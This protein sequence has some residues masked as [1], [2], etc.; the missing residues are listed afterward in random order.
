MKTKN[1]F[2]CFLSVSGIFIF[3]CVLSYVVLT[4]FFYNH[5][6]YDATI[7]NISVSLCNIDSA[8]KT[9]SLIDDS[10][11]LSINTKN[12]TYKIKAKDIDFKYDVSKDKISDV[13]SRQNPFL[14]F[15]P[16]N[17]NYNIQAKI[18]YNKEK[19][20]TILKSFNIN[21]GRKEPENAL[22][23][24][25]NSE[26]I[27]KE[28]NIFD[29]FDEDIVIDEI[30]KCIRN[31]NTSIDIDNN[32]YYEKPQY[33]YNKL[34]PDLGQI[35][36]II[37]KQIS[38][39]CVYDKISIPQDILCNFLLYENH[40]IG[41]N[42]DEIY[43][44][45]NKIAEKYNTLGSTRIFKASN[46]KEIKVLPGN[47]GWSINVDETVDEIKEAILSDGNAYE[48]NA[49]YESTGFK[50]ETT[51][52]DI[53]ATYIEIDIEKQHM[54]FYQDGKLIVETDIVTGNKDGSHDTPK[55]VWYVWSKDSPAILEGD[56]YRV[57]V[58]YWMAIDWTGV[59]IHD[60]TWR[61]SSEYGG[62]TYKYN[63]SHG[64]INTP[65]DNVKKIYENI[66]IGT[67]VVIY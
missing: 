45:V 12:D 66:N 55:G 65:Y 44:Y 63:G 34:L 10:Y 28:E 51:S 67:P 11:E 18:S 49:K 46:G 42:T 41:F 56:D 32:K 3:L 29:Y 2:R 4:C 30:D 15:I 24:K 54:W 53:G 37:R 48:F 50:T 6:F 21:E 17:H 47:Y 31:V 13:L 36:N 60:S 35:N 59:G 8:V 20:N 23:L 40:N 62:S 26:F 61:S 39:N 22:I 43:K 57:E 64:C 7:N 25:E 58:S 38:F 16:N 5:F 27:I 14:W 9:I 52:D 33:T 1:K 19:L